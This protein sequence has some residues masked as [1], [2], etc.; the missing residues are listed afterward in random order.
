[1]TGYE[2]TTLIINILSL[3]ASGLVSFA[4]FYMGKKSDN[5]KYKADVEYQ[6]RKFI[7]DHGNNDILYLPYC[8]IASGVNRHHKHI[9]QI[10][11]DF[12]AL[13]N[14]VQKEVLKQAGSDYQLIESSDWIDE[15]I[16]EI[17]DFA[18]KYDFGDTFLY[19]R[20][21]YFHK[22]FSDHSSA[23]ASKYNEPE[24]LFEDILGWYSSGTISKIFLQTNKLDFFTYLESYYQAFVLNDK[25]LNKSDAIKPLD[26]L[27]V[28]KNFHDCD[29]EEFYFW[30]IEIVRE[31]SILVLR[32]RHDDSLNNID[33]NGEISRGDAD[34]ETFEDK[35]YE[36]LMHLYTLQ[37]DRKQNKVKSKPK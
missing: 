26:Y 25:R 7:I 18:E 13:P 21:K 22:A 24:F 19:E 29:G 27:N 36:A 2:I 28:I 9:R 20:A 32:T 17:I 23:L 16:K 15:G 11:N 3:F 34:P 6:A 30:I 12:N 31:L 35:Y 4:I 5:K 8:V 37:L 1:M 33:I 14:D 10:Y